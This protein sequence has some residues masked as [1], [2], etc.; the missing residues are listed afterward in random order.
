MPIGVRP[1]AS[2]DNVKE[3]EDELVEGLLRWLGF[4]L[5]THGRDLGVGMH[6]QKRLC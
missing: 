2:H 6:F 5:I 3:N 1:S 4:P